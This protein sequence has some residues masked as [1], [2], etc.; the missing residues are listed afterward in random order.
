MA[1]TGL[2]SPLFVIFFNFLGLNTGAPLEKAC[3]MACLVTPLTLKFFKASLL[4]VL[5]NE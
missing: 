1:G 5:F 3:C 2:T 4:V